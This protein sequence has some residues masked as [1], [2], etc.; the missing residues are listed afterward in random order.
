VFPN[1]LAES[2][3]ASEQPN[4]MLI[5]EDLNT[6]LSYPV[7]SPARIAIQHAYGDAQKMMLIAGTAFWAPGVVAVLM[8]R[9]I[10]VTGIKQVRGH[11]A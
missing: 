11:V 1:K 8:W 4:L 6:Q 7:G 9:D 3:P 5:Y 10:K 2:L